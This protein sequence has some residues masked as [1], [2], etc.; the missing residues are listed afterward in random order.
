MT[1][2]DEDKAAMVLVYDSIGGAIEIKYSVGER[3]ENEIERKDP[4]KD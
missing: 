1:T 3:V 2:D 4:K